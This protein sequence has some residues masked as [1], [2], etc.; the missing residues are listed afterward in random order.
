MSKVMA[1]SAFLALLAHVIL[2]TEPITFH[3]YAEECF[4][5]IKLS[6]Y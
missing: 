1:V 4:T 3:L 5:N 6:F 2:Y